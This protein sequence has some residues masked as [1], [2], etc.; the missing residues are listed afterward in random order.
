LICYYSKSDVAEGKL[1]TPSSMSLF[2]NVELPREFTD[3]FNFRLHP[4]G[5]ANSTNQ[6]NAPITLAS[7]GYSSSD[8]SKI[9]LDSSKDCFVTVH[10]IGDPQ[11]LRINLS[12]DFNVL[13][14][15][16]LG[17]LSNYYACLQLFFY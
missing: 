9:S 14:F 12:S 4:K 6:G 13:C 2:A 15:V 11:S 1:Q 16:N 8:D 5:S 17:F 3:P 10:R 7:K